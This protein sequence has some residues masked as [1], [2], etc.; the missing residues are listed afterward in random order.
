[1]P[2]EPPVAMIRRRL[3]ELDMPNLLLDQR[4]F[5]DAELHL[6]VSDGNVT[7]ELSVTDEC[8]PLNSFVGIYTRLI[9][10]DLIRPT[11]EQEGE[12][13]EQRHRRSLYEAL[14]AW[15][16]TSTAR[17]VSRTASMGSNLSKPYQLQLIQ[18]QGFAVP[19][20]LVTNDPDLVRKF[21]SEHERVIYKS[22]SSVRS[23]VRTLREEDL[24]RLDHILWCPTQFQAFVDGVNLRVHTV[25]REVYATAIV[26][27]A[28]DYRYAH[29]QGSSVKMYRYDLPKRLAE[30]CISLAD[31]L[32]LPFA[33]TDLKV[34]TRNTTYCLEVN[35]SPA[36]S[37][38]E[39]HTGQPISRALAMYL[40]GLATF[41][42]R[43]GSR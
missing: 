15:F 11:H 19:E 16:E 30:R 6:E 31:A 36:F 39:E 28:T 38:Y 4:S 17:V 8:Y 32:E 10:N 14:L 41:Q 9:E 25:E 13:P 18:A 33:G 7:G 26:T 24:G 21:W 29:H 3:E 1:M 22:V 23:I 2:S 12:S 27:D 34:D 37:Y 35:P 40:S 43:K 5:D 20:T 42:G